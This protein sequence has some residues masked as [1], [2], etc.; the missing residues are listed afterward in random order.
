MSWQ[1]RVA[2]ALR[3]TIEEFAAETGL[4]CIFTGLAGDSVV[5]LNAAGITARTAGGEY[6]RPVG[7]AFPFAAP[8]G[9]VFAAWGDDA[10]RTT[11]IENSR[12]LL[13]AVDRPALAALVERTREPGYSTMAGHAAAADFER[14]F[15]VAEPPRSEVLKLWGRVSQHGAIGRTPAEGSSDPR[16]E[17]D[18]LQLPV[19]GPDGT[20]AL[21]ITVGGLGEGVNLAEFD[22]VTT[23]ARAFAARLSELAIASGQ[24][25]QR[26]EEA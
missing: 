12:H 3:P 1:R 20:A 23:R 4:E 2:D 8:L 19:H 17:V 7:A 21:V 16:H 22:A 15:E 25:P 18:S 26:G 13:G 14:L 9:A 6:R 24:I 11:W 5:V 10:T